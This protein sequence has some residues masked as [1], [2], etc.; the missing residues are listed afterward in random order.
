MKT[1]NNSVNIRLIPSHALI[2]IYDIIV[3][4]A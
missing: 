3:V 4:I 1:G 2:I